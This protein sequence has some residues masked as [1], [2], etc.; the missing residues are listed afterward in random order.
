MFCRNCGTQMGEDAKFCPRCGAPVSSPQQETFQDAT[1]Q[2]AAQQERIPQGDM[3][4]GAPW[5]GNTQQA[6]VW[7]KKSRGG[8]KKVIIPVAVAAA[9][10]VV[11]I[12][13][14]AIRGT[15][16]FQS[17]FSSPE[18]HYRFVEQTYIEQCVADLEKD[19]DH[20][21]DSL[22]MDIQ[23]EE[24]GLAM[25][26]ITG[27]PE[28][29]AA[30][31]LN[32][33]EI[34]MQSGEEGDLSGASLGL[35]TSDGENLVS[36]NAVVDQENRKMYIQVP[37]LSQGYLMIDSET[38]DSMGGNAI[39]SLTASSP[40]NAD[41]AAIISTYTDI[42]L[43]YAV[44]VE[45]KDTVISADSVEQEAVVFDVSVGGTQFQDM[46]TEMLTAMQEDEALEECINYW[47]DYITFTES[48]QYGGYYT[49]EYSS[50]YSYEEFKNNLKQLTDEVASDDSFKT[51]ELKME[52]WVDSSGEIIGRNVTIS[53][54]AMTMPLFGYKIARNNGIYGFEFVFGDKEDAYGSYI[55]IAGGGVERNGIADGTFTLETDGQTVA[56]IEMSDYNIKSAEDGFLNGTF[57]LSTD[58]DPSLAGLA[59]E[60]TIGSYEGSL[61]ESFSVLSNDVPVAT[62]N[63]ETSE[64]SDYTPSLPDSTEIYNVM[65]EADM[66]A[67]S[68]SM[69]LYA[70][71]ERMRSNEFLDMLFDVYAYY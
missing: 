45:R 36:A 22:I 8:R 32:D 34:R 52:V 67:Y 51:A 41:L 50:G 21:V 16:F 3:S 18:D 26:G 49:D 27:Y 30:D 48:Y 46:L 29:S 54:G 13:A 39:G 17:K 56:E 37:E 71:E 7:P 57:K 58:T 69:D 14:F 9:V 25:L 66:A 63:V 20:S 23:I 31:G 68:E 5:Q 15:Y 33:L 12:G 64:E 43:D 4:Q 28:Q 10:G 19:E 2:D 38:F 24:A 42:F 70:L 44:D 53:D 59:L 40:D 55:Q 11:G 62:L 1:Q 60:I 47:G 61:T 65:N 6:P 35:Y